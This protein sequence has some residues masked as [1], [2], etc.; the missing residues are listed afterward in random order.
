MEWQKKYPVAAATFPY[1]GNAKVLVF[2]LTPR[3]VR[4][5]LPELLRGDPFDVCGPC[6]ESIQLCVLFLGMLLVRFDDPSLCRNVRRESSLDEHEH[7]PGSH[8]QVV[9]LP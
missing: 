8:V 3:S 9:P 4:V 5:T 2:D 6:A 7:A 1:M